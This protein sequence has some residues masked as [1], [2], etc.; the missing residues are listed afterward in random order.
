[1]Y[2]VGNRIDSKYDRHL[3]TETRRWR[4]A[5]LEKIGLTE[6]CTQGSWRWRFSTANDSERVSPQWLD[7]G[8]TMIR[9]SPSSREEAIG[10]VEIARRTIDYHQRSI[11]RRFETEFDQIGQMNEIVFVERSRLKLDRCNLRHVHGPIEP[12]GE[13]RWAEAKVKRNVLPVFVVLKFSDKNFG[14]SPKRR[15]ASGWAKNVDRSFRFVRLEFAR[16]LLRVSAV[17]VRRASQNHLGCSEE[18]EKYVTRSFHR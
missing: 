5:Q 10:P 3:R 4:V 13:R 9:W 2:R 16:V 17:L 18:T 6:R 12:T 1:M 15:V 8:S 14:S 11:V 7:D